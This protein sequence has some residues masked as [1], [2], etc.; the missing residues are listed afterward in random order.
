LKKDAQNLA[1]LRH[2]NLL[3]LIEQPQEDQKLLM[4]VTEPVEFNLA[5]LQ[6]D[7]G[8]KEL[9]PGDLEIKCLARE[10]ME[11]MNFLHNNAKTI[12]MGLAPEHVYI[13]A[14]GKLKLAGL[15]FAVQFSTAESITVPMSHDL[16]INE[17]AMIPNLKYA[18]PE[19]SESQQCSVYSDLFSVGTVLF[20]LVALNKG[21]NPNLL[22]QPDITDKQ[23]HLN[24][25]ST[26]QRK[27]GQYLQGF[28][29]D[30]E[31]LLRPMLNQSP[32]LRG[33]TVDIVN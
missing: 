31:S 29:S 24:E 14:D 8:K 22:T 27:L 1:K 26:M 16:H 18:A 4:F 12:H 6:F 10:L 30:F 11:A 15:N 32:Q 17:Y 20:Y 5:S 28:D 25:C 21:R 9:I 3:S 33:Q 13:T 2:P 7:A 23:S 19:I